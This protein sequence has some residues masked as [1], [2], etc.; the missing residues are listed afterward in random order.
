MTR[1]QQIQT[2]KR[3]YQHLSP[4]LNER[5]RRLWA[6]TEAGELGRGGLS[7][8]CVAIG[9]DHKTVQAGLREIHN[10]ETQADPA[11]IRRK[12][13]G[14]KK[15]TEKDLDLT[16]A[17]DALVE[18]TAAGDP[19]S[20]LRWTCESTTNIAETLTTQG[21]PVSRRSVG[22]L[23]HEQHY[24][25]QG[26]RK[27][28]EGSDHP[29]RDAQFR[30]INE[31]V[32]GMQTKNQPVISVDTKK[33][34]LIGNYKN[35][36]REWRKKGNPRTVNMHDFADP[37]L[38][39]VIPHGIYDLSR[40]EGWVTVGITHDTASFAVASI[41]RWWKRM[42]SKRYPDARELMI[43]ADSGGSNANRSRL[44]KAEL[45]NLAD[46]L[47]MT[48]HVRHFP[49]GTSKWNKIEHRLFSFISRNWRGK[50][51]LSRASVVNLIA[52]TKT[53]AGLTVLVEMDENHYETGRKV[54]D[55]EMESLNLTRESFHGEWNY[56]IEPKSG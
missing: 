37:E 29:D 48:I 23:L 47:K 5:T 45:Q 36:G 27:S 19:E 51:L 4:L 44:W 30:F 42:G 53:N 34:E 28:E 25:L 15:L 43:T 40:N 10:K 1:E 12:G 20:P 24:S 26:N 3:K 39:K 31:S 55:K 7:M 16:Q 14:R 2:I 49:P 38:G 56:R 17:L 18:P 9:I 8:V 33:K 13:G 35:N 11:R 32:K 46:E 52:N 50:P 6:A 41:R 22:N 54:T 21:H